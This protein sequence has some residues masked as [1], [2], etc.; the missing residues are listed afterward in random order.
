MITLNWHEFG[1]SFNLNKAHTALH[2]Q[3]QNISN[4]L[5]LKSKLLGNNCVI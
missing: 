5:N 1:I 3:E 4:I 2:Y